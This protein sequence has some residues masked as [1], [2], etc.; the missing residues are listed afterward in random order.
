MTA[1]ICHTC[2]AG[3]ACSATQSLAEV[4]LSGLFNQKACGADC[5]QSLLS[6]LDKHQPMAQ[7]TAT[8]ICAQPTQRQR[9]AHPANVLSPIRPARLVGRHIL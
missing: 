5:S 4:A 7:L 1:T 9:P 3:Q 2:V 6:H 8:Q